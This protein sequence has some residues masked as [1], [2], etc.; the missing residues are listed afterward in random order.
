MYFVRIFRLAVIEAQRWEGLTIVSYLRITIYVGKV[1]K[2]IFAVFCFPITA[3]PGIFDRRGPNFTQYVETVLQLITSTPRQFNVIL[4]HIPLVQLLRL[5]DFKERGYRLSR[6][7]ICESWCFCTT[8][9]TTALR[10][11]PTIGW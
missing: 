9:V 10:A 3:D 5:F 7:N 4:N 6:C 8:Q 11:E 2:L 1:K